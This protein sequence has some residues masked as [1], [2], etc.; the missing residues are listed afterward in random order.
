[1]GREREARKR[2][3]MVR[4]EKQL[5]IQG[6]KELAP[7]KGGKR[8][9]GGCFRGFAHP[10]SPCALSDWTRLGDRGQGPGRDRGGRS[11]GWRQLERPQGARMAEL[12]ERGAWDTG[13][14][15]PEREHVSE[16]QRGSHR[17]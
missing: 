15:S 10:V 2:R 12:G 9:T 14:G 6:G 3:G 11:K 8:G 13:M 4:T 16:E 5:E 1:M 17:P 7:D